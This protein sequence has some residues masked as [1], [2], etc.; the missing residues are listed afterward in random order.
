MVGKNILVLKAIYFAITF[1]EHLLS[2]RMALCDKRSSKKRENEM[3]T[4]REKKKKEKKKKKKEKKRLIGRFKKH[5]WASILDIIR[6][7]HMKLKLI[8]YFIKLTMIFVVK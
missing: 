7:F 2:V 6:N 3:N 1:L 8:H 4:P 5:W